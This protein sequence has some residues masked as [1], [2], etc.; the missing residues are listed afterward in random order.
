VLVLYVDDM[1]VVHRDQIAANNLKAQLKDKCRMSELGQAR[2]FLGMEIEYE[3]DGPITLSQ[4]HY[5]DTILQR[6]QLENAQDAASP[7]G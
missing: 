3:P 6:F 7:N 5:I 4:S 2:R 1:L